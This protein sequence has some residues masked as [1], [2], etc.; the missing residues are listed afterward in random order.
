MRTG[1]REINALADPRGQRRS[2]ISHS[3]LTTGCFFA[4]E[5]ADIRLSKMDFLAS[6]QLKRPIRFQTAQFEASTNDLRIWGIHRF[7]KLSGSSYRTAQRPIAK[8][9]TSVDSTIERVD[10]TPGCALRRCPLPQKRNENAFM[11]RTKAAARRRGA[12]S[13]L[14]PHNGAL[15]RNVHSFI[16]RTIA[17]SMGVG[18]EHRGNVSSIGRSPRGALHPSHLGGW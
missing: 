6:G 4:R 7:R 1:Q 3:P 5:S 13:S 18:V 11:R 9:K 12:S 16:G 15:E 14:S 2:T 17:A 10:I 8:L